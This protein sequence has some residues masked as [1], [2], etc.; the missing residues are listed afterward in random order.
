MEATKRGKGEG[1][2]GMIGSTRMNMPQ[3]WVSLWTKNSPIKV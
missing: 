2:G 1:G 3:V